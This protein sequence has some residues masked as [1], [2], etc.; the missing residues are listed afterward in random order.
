MKVLLQEVGKDLRAP[1]G[2]SP[3]VFTSRALF[4][5]Y[6]TVEYLE[7]HSSCVKVQDQVVVAVLQISY[8]AY[9]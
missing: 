1:V 3:L 4:G 6:S 2:V 7:R 5:F 8:L 9:Y